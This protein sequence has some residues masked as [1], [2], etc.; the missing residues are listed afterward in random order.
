MVDMLARTYYQS[1]DTNKEAL[2]LISH[3]LKYPQYTE[4]VPNSHFSTTCKFC[5]W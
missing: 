4:E 3:K 1:T 2:Q 5:T